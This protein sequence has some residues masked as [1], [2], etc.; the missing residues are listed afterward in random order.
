MTSQQ[1]P[2]PA[3]IQLNDLMRQ[4]E[5]GVIK[6]PQF[7]RDFVWSRTKSAKLIDSLLRGFPIGTFILWRTKEQLRTIRNIGDIDFPPTQTGDYTQYVLDGQQRLTSVFAILHGAKLNRDGKEEDFS[8]LYIDLDTDGERDLVVADVSGMEPFSYVPIHLLLGERILKELSNYPEEYRNKMLLYRESI[9]S[10]SSSIV[11]VQEASIDIATEIFT[12]INVSGVPLTVFE[13]M[14][15][16]TFDTGRDFDLS[17]KTEDIL[18]KLYDIGYGTVREIVVLQ[19]VSA[20]MVKETRKRNILELDK[21]KFIDTWS[22]A[23][24]GILRAVDYLRSTLGVPVSELLPYQSILVPLAYFFANYRHA[25]PVGERHNHLVDYFWRTSLAGHYSQSLDTRLAQD[26]RRID[27]I[28]AGRS[29]TYDYPVDPSPDLISRNGEFKT[30]RAFVKAILCLL[31]GR[32][33]RRFDNH[34]SRINVNNDW[35]KRANSKNYHHFFPK[36]VLEDEKYAPFW[37][38]HIVNIT[39]VDEEL[40]KARIKAKK[41][42]EYMSQFSQENE[43]LSATMETHFIDIKDDGIWDKKFGGSGDAIDDYDKFFER[44]CHRISSVLKKMIVAQ[45]I[46][47]RGQSTNTEDLESTEIPE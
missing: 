31:A 39:I 5:Q 12:R 28:L 27:D 37:I 15:A 42:S 2:Q 20:V 46:D 29:P 40:N 24:S 33:P 10:Y 19:A 8:Q 7:Q 35:L 38:N 36:K 45:P 18:D 30:G 47:R 17:H 1:M 34:S 14:V 21:Q 26:I 11:L 23:E 16:K 13:I 9:R 32:E 3:A 25:T 44:R 43:Q 41:P 22:M 6:I 4:I